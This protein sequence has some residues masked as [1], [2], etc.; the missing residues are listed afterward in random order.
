MLAPTARFFFTFFIKTYFSFLQAAKTAKA[1]AGRDL[2]DVEK[3]HHTEAQIVSTLR[4][5]HS[6][7]EFRNPVPLREA[8]QIRL[9]FVR[10]LRAACFTSKKD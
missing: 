3:R 7:L 10:T 8:S 5:S 9:V 4:P 1:N 6:F 2:E